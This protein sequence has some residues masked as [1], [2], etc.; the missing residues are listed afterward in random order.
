MTLQ[1]PF[2]NR[3]SMKEKD[4]EDTLKR[5]KKKTDAISDISKMSLESFNLPKEMQNEVNTY[6]AKLKGSSKEKLQDMLSGSPEKLEAIAT[7]ILNS[8]K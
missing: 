2:T 3:F 7:Q 1:K 6:I 4:L 5:L 8:H